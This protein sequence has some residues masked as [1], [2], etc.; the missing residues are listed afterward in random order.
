MDIS[1]VFLT[2]ILLF[3]LA[4]HFAALAGVLDFELIVKIQ[5]MNIM[6]FLAILTLE[7]L[8]YIDEQKQKQKKRGE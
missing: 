6:S 3:S 7:V 4:I 8:Y 5:L 1:K 2:L